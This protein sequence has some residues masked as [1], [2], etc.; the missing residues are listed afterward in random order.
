MKILIQDGLAVIDTDYIIN[1]YAKINDCSIVADYEGG[2]RAC[3]AAVELGM[4]KNLD[5][6]KYALEMFYLAWGDGEDR[7]EFPSNDEVERLRAMEHSGQ[8][9]IHVKTKANRHG[10]S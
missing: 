4:Y 6:T 3:G 10:A 5:N 8:S 1:V 7:F 9:G 2:Y